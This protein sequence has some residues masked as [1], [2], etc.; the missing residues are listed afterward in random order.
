L[1]TDVYMA[2]KC[3]RCGEAVSRSQS[4]QRGLFFVL[5]AAAFG[6]FQC[7]KCGKIPRKEFPAGDRRKMALGSFLMAFV[8]IA[9]L[10][11][12]VVALVLAER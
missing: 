10:A 3:P 7:P 11:G 8:A 5:L 9:V 1:F 4:G 6:A 2:Y 12:A